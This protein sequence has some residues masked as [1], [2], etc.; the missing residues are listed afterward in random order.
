M[1]QNKEGNEEIANI[2]DLQLKSLEI[3]LYFKAFCESNG[4]RFFLCGGCCIGAVR[5]KGF[6]PWD[7]DVDVFMPRADYE[8]LGGLWEKY[9][10][11]NRYSYCRTNEDN[12]YETMLT[13][14]ADN[15]TTFIKKNLCDYDINHGI[16]LEI[17]PLD[18]S[19]NSKLKRKF[20]ILRA[21]EFCLFNRQVVPEN[22]GKAAKI[23]GFL[24][25]KIFRSPKARYKLWKSAESK[26]T[27]YPLNGETKYL[28]ELCVT[29]KYLKN[30]YPKEIFKEE[31]LMEFEGHEMPVPIGYDTYLKI[32]FGDYMKLPPEEERAPKHEAVYIDL[33]NSYTKYK[34]IYYCTN[35]KN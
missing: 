6:I 7:D 33:N 8:K 15:N 22:K 24:L 4:L 23:L 20:Q 32:A 2:R 35:D 21:I 13:Q 28:T 12:S 27:K 34:G 14:I 29:Y 19:P 3:L 25:L 9:A 1:G 11:K 5:H 31:V 18:A 26:M 10:D 30:Q 16:K 17:V